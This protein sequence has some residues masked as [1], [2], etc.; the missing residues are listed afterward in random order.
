MEALPKAGTTLPGAEQSRARFLELCANCFQ[1]LEMGQLSPL[2][3]Q[4]RAQGLPVSCQDSILEPLPKFRNAQSSPGQKFTEFWVWSWWRRE[5]EQWSRLLGLLLS[6]TPTLAEGCH[7]FL[8]LP[9]E[10]HSWPL[11]SASDPES[12]ALYSTTNWLEPTQ[13]MN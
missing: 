12:C 1:Y 2:L 5:R 4:S 8:I 7:L 13:K 9:E 6:W 3:P 10:C 11:V